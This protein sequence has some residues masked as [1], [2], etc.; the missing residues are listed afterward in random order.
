MYD[1]RCERATI[2]REIEMRA[3]K[4]EIPVHR[5]KLTSAERFASLALNL[6]HHAYVG[7]LRMREHPCVPD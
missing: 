7:T 3:T 4:R 2:E 1:C 5:G 6:D